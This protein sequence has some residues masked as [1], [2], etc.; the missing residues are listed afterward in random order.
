MILNPPSA[1]RNPAQCRRGYVLIAV[2]LVIV[3]L[4]LAAY[5]F[6]DAMTGEYRAGARSSESAQARAAAVSGVHYAA[7]VLAD[8]DAFINYLNGD[9]TLD[10]FGMWGDVTVRG[11]EQ[12]K[13]AKF[14]VVSVAPA[15]AGSYEQR[16][17]LTDEGGKLNINALIAQ[18]KTGAVLRNAL[19]KIPALAE[20]PEVVDAIVDWVDADEEAGNSETGGGG[21]GA[22]NTYYEALATPYKCKNG[23]LNSVEELLL[24]SGVTPQLLFGTDQNR[25]GV[26]DDGGGQTLDRG[27]A[28]YV[29]VYGREV[30]VDSTGLQ[31][32]VWING[33][34]PKA[35][36]DALL[37]SGLDQEIVAYIMAAKL[38][39]RT[40][41]DADGNPIQKGGKG[42]PPPKTRAASLDELIS[43]VENRL[44]ST[45]SSGRV[46]NS[47]MQL[48]STRVSLPGGGG[49][50]TTVYNSPF[51]SPDRLREL[52]PSV[53]D[54]VTTKDAVEMVPRLNV[55][56]APREVLLGLPG[57]T[58]EDVDAIVGA[59]QGVVADATSPEYTTGAWLVTAANLTPQKFQAIEKYVTGS[60]MVYRVESVGYLVGG[61]PAARVEAVIDIGLG[62]PRIVYF[63]DLGEL[64]N[65]R[66]F[67]TQTA[68]GMQP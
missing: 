14:R 28:D 41:L 5:R 66:G 47:V 55:N 21:Q 8:R 3:V 62:A 4:S 42:G 36:Y 13:E 40:Q 51:N 15:G 34:D 64:D 68:T 60:S 48:A 18:D 54:K 58:E 17:A 63:R 23:P 49:G 30:C 61:G 56:T 7:A 45:S 19:L 2:L 53:L 22:E 67:P 29:T 52:L 35:V 57:L 25:N 46:L 27:L 9:P 20:L 59:R 50:T 6:T 12:G 24:V 11:A 43:A 33:E 39:G 1:I 38:F 10:N 26:A 44:A 31:L 16:F 32:K 65:P 37:A